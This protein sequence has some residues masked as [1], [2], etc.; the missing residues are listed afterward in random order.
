MFVTLMHSWSTFL[1]VSMV[2][3]PLLGYRSG[4]ILQSST[5]RYNIERF[6]TMRIYIVF[7]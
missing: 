6:I 2:L 4:D 7:T 1:G 5:K 3:L